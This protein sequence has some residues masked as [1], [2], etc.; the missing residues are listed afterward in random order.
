MIAA[1]PVNLALKVRE[2][3]RHMDAKRLPADMGPFPDARVYQ[4]FK[5]GAEPLNGSIGFL[6]TYYGSIRVANQLFNVVIVRILFSI[7]CRVI[8]FSCLCAFS[9]LDCNFLPPIAI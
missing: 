9:A 3:L 5:R 1:D 4:T 7:L 6:G 2:P 8:Y